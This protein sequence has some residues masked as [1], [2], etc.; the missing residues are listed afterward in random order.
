MLWEYDSESVQESLEI[1]SRKL[2][3]LLEYK[4]IEHRH[5]INENGLDLPEIRNWKRE[6]IK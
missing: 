2:K 4:L 6:N 1:I 5:Y 3:K